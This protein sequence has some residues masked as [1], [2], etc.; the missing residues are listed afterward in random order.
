MRGQTGL[1]VPPRSQIHPGTKV[2][3]VQKRDQRTGALT[4]GIVETILTRSPR[5]PHG[6]K[7][8]L[9]GGVVGRVQA[10]LDSR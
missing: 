3:V 9:V 2:A 5:H 6:I 1:T 8:R 4:E 7:V 10:V